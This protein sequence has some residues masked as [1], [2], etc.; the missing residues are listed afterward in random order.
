MY[1]AYP[2]LNDAGYAGYGSWSVASQTPLFATFYAGYVASTYL[3]NKTMAIAE[4][5]FALTLAKLLP[6]NVTSLFVSLSMVEAIAGTPDQYT[7]NTIEL[8]SGGQVFEDAADAQSGVNPAWR[9]SYFSNIVA[10][11]WAPGTGEVCK[12]RHP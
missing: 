2:D 11:G 1:Q 5:A 10:R 7:S 12:Q 4:S 3:F 8:V 9:K 6:Y